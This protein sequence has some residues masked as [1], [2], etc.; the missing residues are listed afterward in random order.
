M[1]SLNEWWVAHGI[2]LSAAAF[3]KGG[4]Q[5]WEKESHR[6][7]HTMTS[8]LNLGLGSGGLDAMADY[9]FREFK[10]VYPYAFQ[11]KT[12]T[13]KDDNGDLVEP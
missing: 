8:P 12:K 3:G 10:S 7:E 5:L 13:G 1:F 9:R 6:A 4:C 2:L 11:D